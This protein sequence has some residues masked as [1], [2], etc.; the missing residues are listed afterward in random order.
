MEFKEIVMNRYAVKSF[1]GKKV[2]E[3]KVN[4]LIEMVRH[5]ASSFNVQPWHIYIVTDKATKDKI[6]KAAWD[7]PQ[8]GTSSHLLVFV[9]NTDVRG[10]IQKL[11]HMMVKT[12][13][14]MEKMQAY[15]EM[16]NGFAQNLTP[17]NAL[18]WTQKQVYLA[19]GNALNGA[20]SLGFDSCPMEGFDPKEVAKIL[21]LPANHIPTVLV[22]IGYANDTPRIKTR[23]ETKDLV[24][25][26]N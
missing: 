4:E 8:I 12:T 18:N 11:E 24:T 5:S 1:D 7:Q 26:V 13:K 16:I 6:Q 23:F 14:D 21:K 3:N 15:I 22:P 9:A 19:L 25:N 20:K 10:N 17:E 2:P